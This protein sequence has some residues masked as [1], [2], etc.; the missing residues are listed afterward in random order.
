[1]RRL[2][3]EDVAMVVALVARR[4]ERLLKRRRL[5]SELMQHALALLRL[6]DENR[7]LTGAL[8]A[9]SKEEGLSDANA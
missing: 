6:L 1:M 4:V 3:R 8:S 9:L 5:I 2:T 7:L